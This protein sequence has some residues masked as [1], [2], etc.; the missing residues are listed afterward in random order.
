MKRTS[1]ILAMVSALVMMLTLC[2]SSQAQAQA[3]SLQCPMTGDQYLP[4]GTYSILIEADMSTVS[5]TMPNVIHGN[6]YY[7]ANRR[8]FQGG[9]DGWCTD[10]VDVT[11]AMYAFGNTCDAPATNG[12]RQF[13]IDRISGEIIFSIPSLGS[14][15]R[16]T[17]TKTELHQRF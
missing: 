5:V 2:Y 8:M 14:T 1:L 6:L 7:K 11:S 10:Y 17:C 12:G 9:T 4:A 13:K 16:G 15:Y 3:V